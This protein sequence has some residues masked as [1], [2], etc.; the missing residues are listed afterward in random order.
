MG[1]TV[2]AFVSPLVHAL[3]LP[4]VKKTSKGRCFK[5]TR[6]IRLPQSRKTLRKEVFQSRSRKW[7]ECWVPGWKPGDCK[8]AVA[9]GPARYV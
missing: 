6:D 4:K 8:G 1:S 7:Q 9:V 5:S 3:G 2:K